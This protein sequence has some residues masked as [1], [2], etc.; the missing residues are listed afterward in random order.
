M[1]VIKLKKLL[2]E[3]KFAF[4]RE[5]GEPLPTFED[6]M[7]KHQTTESDE[8]VSEVTKST[9]PECGHEY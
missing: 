1:K 6:V 3:S 8:K 4:D 5:F 7:E 9:C 2:K